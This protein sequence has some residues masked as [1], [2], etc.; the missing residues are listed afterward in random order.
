MGGDEVGFEFKALVRKPAVI[1]HPGTFEPR[2]RPENLT[3][4]MRQYRDFGEMRERPGRDDALTDIQQRVL[5]V[6]PDAIEPHATR[7]HRCFHCRQV[8]PLRPTVIGPR[9]RLG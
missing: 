6:A 2:S 7:W 5:F 1:Q 8:R 9:W 4:P 3:L